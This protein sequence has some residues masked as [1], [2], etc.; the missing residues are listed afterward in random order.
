MSTGPLDK[1]MPEVSRGINPKCPH[2]TTFCFLA[3]LLES[4]DKFPPGFGEIEARGM[5]DGTAQAH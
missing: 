4:I 1:H 2:L 5:R 3:G